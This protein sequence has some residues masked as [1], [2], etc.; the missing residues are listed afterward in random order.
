MNELKK[1]D[2]NIDFKLD[3][4]ATMFRKISHKRFETY[5]IQ[6]IWHRLND[7]EIQFV[8]QQYVDRP[9]DDEYA[10]ADL[11]LP[12]VKSTSICSNTIDRKST[13]ESPDR[14]R[15]LCRLS[16]YDH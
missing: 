14:D 4:M 11:Y 9:K 15:I 1:I 8:T 5:V 12:Q 13:R 10:L 16:R 2:E 7:N 6:R 3:Y